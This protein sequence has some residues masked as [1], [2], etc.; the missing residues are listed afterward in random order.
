MHRWLV[1]V[2]ANVDTTTSAAPTEP[3]GTTA[4]NEA[5]PVTATLVAGWPPTVTVVAPTRKLEPE[6]DTCV[7]PATRPRAGLSPLMVG[8]ATTTV[9][10]LHADQLAQFSSSPR[11]GASGRS[12]PGAAG[13]A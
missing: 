3:G 7:P 13:S 12:R 9:N 11:A 2:P 5:S 4:V 10:G 6:I 1:A 8:G